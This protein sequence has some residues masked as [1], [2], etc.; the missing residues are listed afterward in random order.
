MAFLLTNISE[1]QIH[2]VRVLLFNDYKL[3]EWAQ[4]TNF[5]TVWMTPL[6]P[7]LV[8][9]TTNVFITIR[10]NSKSFRVGCR[11]G[12]LIRHHLSKL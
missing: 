12:R 2:E 10:K 9:P 8:I 3:F 6:F 5:C 4:T 7:I 1:R 11:Q